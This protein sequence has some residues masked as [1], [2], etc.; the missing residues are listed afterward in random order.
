ML[1]RAEG[2]LAE[3]GYVAA[4]RARAETRLY[5]VGPE[6][7][8]DAGLGRDE[9][10]P[11][12]RRLAGALARTAAEPPALARLATAG[13]GERLPAPGETGP[14]R[15]GAPDERL[16]AEHAC[17][18]DEL[19]AGAPPDSAPELRRLEDE[20]ARLGADLARAEADLARAERARAGIGPV[21]ML[22]RAGQEEAARHERAAATAASRAREITVVLAESG[23]HRQDLVARAAKGELWHSERLAAL[24]TRLEATERRLA[25]HGRMEGAM[26]APLAERP[27]VELTAAARTLTQALERSRPPD[28]RGEIAGLRERWGRLEHAFADEA[29]RSR[30]CAAALGQLGPRRLT[31]PGREEGRRLHAMIER[32]E[33]AQERLRSQRTAVAQRLAALGPALE[34]WERWERDLAPVLS[35][36]AEIIEAEI[37][38][39]VN[40]RRAEVAREPPAYLTT[41]LGPRPAPGRG[42]ER[43]DQG[44]A[45]IE[46]YRVRHGVSDPSRALGPATVDRL[47]LAERR[48]VERAVEDVRAE[49]GYLARAR[50][51]SDTARPEPGYD[52]GPRHDLERAMDRRLDRGPS[53]G[54]GR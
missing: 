45:A 54:V 53:R 24:L 31:R 7:A 50:E 22:G 29:A 16:R 8:A 9:P 17:L 32:S 15:P 23:R 25:A 4:S 1:V 14:P 51:R 42:Q 43:W 40:A 33:H 49:L 6:L 35:G 2:A 26:R 39:R 41:A 21:R 3:W 48:P 34:R 13:P 30:R 5:A 10:Q 11:T 20:R 18:L 37:D 19:A 27:G 12:T 52:H 46:G 47:L 28:P 38:R 44:A 36:R